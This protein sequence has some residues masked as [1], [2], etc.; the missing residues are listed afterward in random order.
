MV[1]K[2]TKEMRCATCGRLLAEHAATG[3]VIVCRSCKTRNTAE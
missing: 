2:Q 1:T 3:T